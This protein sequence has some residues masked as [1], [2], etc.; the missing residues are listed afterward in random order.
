MQSTVDKPETV[1]PADLAE[2]DALVS[3][4]DTHISQVEIADGKESGS[5][6]VCSLGCGGGGGG[7]GG[8]SWYWYC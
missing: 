7:G 8:E 1:D 6:L 5:L 4:L 3:Q 2:L